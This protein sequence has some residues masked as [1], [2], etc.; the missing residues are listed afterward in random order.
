MDLIK[1]W[2]HVLSELPVKDT[3]FVK[4]EKKIHLR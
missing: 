1:V 2:I 3:L 4:L